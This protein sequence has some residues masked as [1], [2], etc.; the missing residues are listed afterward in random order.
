MQLNRDTWFTESK[1][2][3]K[4][5]LSGWLCCVEGYLSNS[6]LLSLFTQFPVVRGRDEQSCQLWRSQ[7][8][9]QAA[10]QYAAIII[11]Q[12][13]HLQGG[14]LLCGSIGHLNVDCD[15]YVEIYRCCQQ[16]NSLKDE[17]CLHLVNNL[18]LRQI[19]IS[20]NRKKNLWS[21]III[22]PNWHN[23]CVKTR[24]SPKSQDNSRSNHRTTRRDQIKFNKC[25]VF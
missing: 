21:S 10:H 4:I 1:S 20:Q 5:A 25:Q 24:Q 9:Q 22:E 14:G 19:K 11:K 13:L 3:V 8:W 16:L 7:I 6:K 23:F 12:S 18:V 17:N 15:R 2:S